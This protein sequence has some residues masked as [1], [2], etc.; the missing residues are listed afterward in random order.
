MQLIEITC[1]NTDDIL[2]L[3]V[4]IADAQHGASES[5]YITEVDYLKQVLAI[6]D[7]EK[8]IN[9]LRQNGPRIL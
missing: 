9:G 6:L 4:R 1:N 3:S 5:K 8:S 7:E 2:R